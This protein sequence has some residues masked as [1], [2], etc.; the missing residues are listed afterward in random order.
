MHRCKV[1]GNENVTNYGEFK[2]FALSRCQS[3][4]YVTK[5]FGTDLARRIAEGS[6]YESGEWIDTRQIDQS[7]RKYAQ[8]LFKIYG[9]RLKKGAILEIGPGDGWNL[10]VLRDAGWKVEGVES[11]RANCEFIRNTHGITVIND[12]FENSRLLTGFENVLLSHVIEHIEQPKGFLDKIIDAL[13]AGGILVVVT[14][15]LCSKW[16]RLWGPRWS[17]YLVPDHVSFFCTKHLEMITADRMETVFKGSYEGAIN[18]SDTLIGALFNRRFQNRMMARLDGSRV[19][20]LAPKR[21]GSLFTN[22]RNLS[23]KPFKRLGKTEQGTD[24]IW[25]SRKA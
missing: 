14:P 20:K 24:L 15:N 21:G 11:S 23:G 18:F 10:R 5:T 3:C 6:V 13:P 22:L 2:Y 9:P 4:G 16:S 8:E 19:G 17:S 12:R 25:I 7:S 1:C